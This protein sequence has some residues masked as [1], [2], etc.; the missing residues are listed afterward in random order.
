MRE[1]I[2]RLE[3]ELA[4]ARRAQAFRLDP[5][6]P[7]AVQGFSSDGGSV[8]R[9]LKADY[10]IDQSW[11]D[12][13][14]VFL[15]GWVHAGPQV[16]RRLSLVAGQ[17]Q[18]DTEIFQP[19]ADVANHYFDLPGGAACGFTLY[20]ACPAHLAFSLVVQT[21]AGAA[22]L[23]VELAMTS[24]EKEWDATKPSERF[25]ETMTERRGT[26]LELGARPVASIVHDWRGKFEPACR[27]LGNDIHPGPNIDVV[28]DVHSLSAIVAPGSLDGLFSI[29]VLE[30]LVAPWLAA[31]E[32]NRCLK[33]GGETLHVTHQTY[34]IHETPNDYF[35]MSDQA[36]RSLFGPAHGF[37]VIEC[38]LA[39]PVRIMPPTYMRY[40]SWLQVPMGRGYVQSFIRAR[41]V[42]EVAPA[43][44][45]WQAD[46]L[47]RLSEE[48]PLPA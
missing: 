36:L 43:G 27:Y 7:D 20:L 31:V 48:Y 12:T 44:S 2:D 47:T 5:S 38:G 45:A 34:P 19:R 4:A 29:A 42:A 28:G 32:I 25:V 24:D 9:R 3:G 14:G 22:E 16:V 23:P 26:V 1:H 13:G 10:F 35:R 33:I 46:V 17:Y 11:R 41:K 18:A 21:D 8:A 6:G 40:S 15:N 30:H 39:H 37:E